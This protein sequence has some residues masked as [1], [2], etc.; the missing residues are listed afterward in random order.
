MR[1][2]EEIT[3]V[4]F[5]VKKRITPLLLAAS[6]I[7][8]GFTGYFVNA[9]PAMA[10][11]RVDEL[12]DV[13]SNTW[14]YSALKNLVEK[15]NVI[16][17]YPDKTFRGD[18]A[19]TRYEM[20]AAL[21]A[22]VKA[23]GKE[24]ARL[25]AEKADKED[26]A[27]VAKLQEEFATELKTLQARSDAL[28]ARA[29]KIEAKNDEQ[30]NRLA[31]L[32]KLKVYGDVSFGGLSSIAGNPPGTFSDGISAVGR[33]RINVDYTAIED[34]GGAIVG[35]GVIHTRLIG[36]FGRVSP[37]EAGNGLTRN[38][39]SGSSSIAGDSSLYNEGIR[40]NDFISIT[41]GNVRTA[42]VGTVTGGNLR[43]NA[44]VDSAYYSQ[45]L[46]ANIPYLPTGNSWKTAFTVDMGVI[47]WKDIYF[48]S[49][50]QG[51]DNAEFQNTA[52]QNNAAILQNFTIPR[53]ALQMNQG[54]GR[55]ASAKVTT[56]A[57]FLDTSDAMNGLGFTVEGD[58]GYNLGFIDKFLCTQDLF[59]LPGN[60]FGGYYFVHP[61]GG[62][63]NNLVNVTTT[64]STTGVVLPT[65]SG[66]GN[67]AQG[68]Y[69][70]ANQ[71]IF[72]G[73]GI[74]GSYALNNTGPTAALLS[75]LQNGTGTNTIYN[76]SISS[77]GS[78][79]IYGVRQAWT[80]GFE[81]PVEHCQNLLPLINGKEMFLE[82]Q[83][84][85][86]SPIHLSVH[87]LMEFQRLN[88]QQEE[89]KKSLKHIIKCRLAMVLLLSQVFS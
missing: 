36:A 56:D 17:G 27:T 47:P 70:G 67:T 45:V 20:A 3:G 24:I 79:L 87:P 40:P 11:T 76:N 69:A 41:D 2:L 8:S 43:A 78:T 49:P 28:E 37:L 10:I 5:M 74:F 25:G 55:W 63:T 23:M 12:S 80:A 75:A 22:T 29:S 34:K 62:G 58:L 39:L 33:T 31:I 59:N 52:L 82:Q 88:Q 68:F 65:S 83:Y 84:L 73:F 21:N 16:E 54:L 18:R 57:S 19:P 86:F 71:E 1:V 30:D 72:R 32:E 64:A 4:G 15:Y 61:Q 7:V 13:C 85:S 9:L 53:V 48:K 66:F 38:Q 77:G 26:L 42:G 14:A 35:P 6:V 60:I 44:Y 46:R 89:G 81:L 50:Y 51:D